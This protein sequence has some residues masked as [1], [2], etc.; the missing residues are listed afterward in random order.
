MNDRPKPSAAARTLI[1]P[2]RR[3]ANYVLALLTVVY[4][5]NYLDRQLLSVLMVPIKAEFGVSDGQLGWLSG[6]LFAAIYTVAGIP[7]ARIADVFGRRGVIAVGLTIWS[8]MTA[9]TGFATSFA[10]L[11]I[12]RVGVAL[13]ES[14][15]TPPSF[16]L[17]SDY[18]TPERR[19]TALGIFATGVSLGTLLGNVLGGWI[20]HEFGWRA[21]FLWLGAPGLALALL[22]ILTVRE[23]QRTAAPPETSFFDVVGV[24]MGK[25]AFWWMVGGIS[26]SAFAGYGFGVW[27]PTFLMRVHEFSLKDAGFA[28]GFVNLFTG[29]LSSLLGGWL[30]D[31]LGKRNPRWPMRVAALSA[32]LALPF[33]LAF[34]FYPNPWIALL[35]IAPL[36]AVGGM[37]PPPTYAGSQNLVPAHMRAL[38][39]AIMLFFLN[40]VG[41]GLGP[42]LI[43]ELSDR[44]SLE[45][46]AQSIRYA[47]AGGVFAY[48]LGAFCYWRASRAIA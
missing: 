39:T 20:G 22:F 6:F 18:F 12:A 11:R 44:L 19:A 26:F 10:Q 41:L 28:V 23:P 31:R 42:W 14:G 36:G 15:G 7:V 37:W 34:L 48:L 5:F 32:L 8:A 16:A 1:T 25:P 21:A 9:L 47:L 24:L 38:T 40:G 35:V 3:Y 45:Y 27:K 4:A 30:A 29:I 17:I 33:T 43:G 13:G 46:G 2:S